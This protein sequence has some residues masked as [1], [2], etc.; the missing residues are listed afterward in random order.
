MLVTTMGTKFRFGGAA[1][2]AV[3]VVLLLLGV[4]FVLSS[5][6]IAP[7]IYTLF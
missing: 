6:A 4:L 2:C 3:T 5:S 7:L 1:L